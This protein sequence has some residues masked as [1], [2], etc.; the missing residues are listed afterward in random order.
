MGQ[1]LLVHKQFSSWLLQGSILVERPLPHVLRYASVCWPVVNEGHAQAEAP[2]LCLGNDPVQGS[3]DPLVKNSG[4]WLQRIPLW[5][6]S[7]RPSSLLCLLL[8][9][10]GVESAIACLLCLLGKG[11]FIAAV[12][13]GADSQKAQVLTTARSAF[14]AASSTSVTSC[15]RFGSAARVCGRQPL[16][17]NNAFKTCCPTLKREGRCPGK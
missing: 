7:C 15:L 14:L 6:I 3:K 16:E 8:G 9:L 11:A 12:S 5:P 17:L 2:G 13:E 4:L 10:E 1:C